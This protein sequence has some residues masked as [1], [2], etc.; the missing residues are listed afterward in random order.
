MLPDTENYEEDEIQEDLT[1][2]TVPDKTY[3][4]NFDTL[5]IGGMV[6]DEEA[7]C[8]AVQKIL[9]TEAEEAPVYD[10]G[11]GRIYE[12]LIGKPMTFALS[13]VKMRIEDAVL[14][15]ERFDSVVFT[16]WEIRKRAIVLSMT[17]TCSDGSEIEMEGVEISV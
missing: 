14:Q 9:L 11:Y 4:L 16:S 6:D 3:R 15:D 5:T 1:E 7:K 13:E 2:E 17:V 8:Q 10:P 12:D